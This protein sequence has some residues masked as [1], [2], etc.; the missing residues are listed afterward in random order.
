MPYFIF[1]RRQNASLA[2]PAGRKKVIIP[3]PSYHD[4]S[5]V[6]DLLQKYQD[7]HGTNF[8]QAEAEKQLEERRKGTYK[9]TPSVKNRVRT[10][11]FTEGERRENERKTSP[12]TKQR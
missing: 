4:G 6:K 10:G 2:I 8:G 7:T 12:N 11:F 1:K 5:Q 9:D 3:L